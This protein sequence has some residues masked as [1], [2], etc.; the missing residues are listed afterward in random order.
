MRTG[1]KLLAAAFLATASIHSHAA[2]E[3]VLRLDEDINDDAR[4]IGPWRTVIEAAPAIEIPPD[5]GRAYDDQLSSEIAR[6]LQALLDASRR[7][8]PR[9][10]TGC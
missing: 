1:F 9:L 7:R 4:V 10:A 8:Q 3:T 2:A 6:T 5:A